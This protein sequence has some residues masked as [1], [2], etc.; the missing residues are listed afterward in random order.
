[1]VFVNKKILCNDNNDKL[2]KDRKNHYQKIE[3]N[4]VYMHEIFRI[5]FVQ[6]IT[7]YYPYRLIKASRFYALKK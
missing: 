3:M 2:Q 4:I 5:M 7:M 1:M 6:S